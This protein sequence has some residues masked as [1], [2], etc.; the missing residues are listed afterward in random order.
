[1]GLVVGEVR[2]YE[3]GFDKHGAAANTGISR[4]ELRS[5]AQAMI[6]YFGGSRNS[7]QVSVTIAGKERPF[8]NERELAHMKDVSDLMGLDRTVQ[9][10]SLGYV[11]LFL[12][13]GFSTK[14]GLFW[15]TLLRST[16][17]ASGLVLFIGLLLGV[18]VLLNFDQLFLQF[19]LVSF[20]NN[21]WMLNPTTD[22]LIRIVPQGFF[23]DAAIIITLATVAE[24]AVLGGGALFLLSRR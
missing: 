22:Y 24:A 19:H 20:S 8:Y 23:Q 15:S 13:V 9:W 21:L 3:Y 12:V 18:G 11:A 16:L 10:L 2:L 17:W 6:D 4:D 5:L 14:R 7:P 1:M